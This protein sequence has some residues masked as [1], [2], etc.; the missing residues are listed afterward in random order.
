M[1]FHIVIITTWLQIAKHA[2]MALLKMH[3]IVVLKTHTGYVF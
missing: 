2:P 3:T 1:Q